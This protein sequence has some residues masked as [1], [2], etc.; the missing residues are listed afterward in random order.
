MIYIDREDI[1][2]IKS[3]FEVNPFFV[4][5][6]KFVWELFLLWAYVA[7]FSTAVFFSNP[8][9]DTEI[10]VGKRIERTIALQSE[11]SLFHIG[12]LKYDTTK[13]GVNKLTKEEIDDLVHTK[14]ANNVVY[15]YLSDLLNPNE[16]RGDESKY[17]KY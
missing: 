6:L 7:L 2:T 4:N 9:F 17:I 1:R 10:S 8:L 3:W 13:H 12:F 15:K 11:Y 16:D 5:N 14:R